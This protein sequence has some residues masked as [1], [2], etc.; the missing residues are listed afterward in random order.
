MEKYIVSPMFYHFACGLSAGIFLQCAIVNAGGL[1][2]LWI[3]AG[4]ISTVLSGLC[5]PAMD[6]QEVRKLFLTNKPPQ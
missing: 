6:M 3:A 1:W 2:V 5:R 4:S